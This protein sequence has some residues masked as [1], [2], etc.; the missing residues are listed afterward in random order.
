[1]SINYVIKAEVVD[2]QTDAPRNGD[3]FLVDSNVWF[4]MTYVNASADSMAYQTKDYPDYVSKALGLGARICCSGLSMAELTHL[5]ETNERK[6][7]SQYCRS[8]GTKEYRHNLPAER[9]RIVK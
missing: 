7:Y 3:V 6:I 4:W 9:A 5:I 2:I 8:I 1:M